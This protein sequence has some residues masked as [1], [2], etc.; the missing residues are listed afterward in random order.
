MVQRKAYIMGRSKKKP[1]EAWESIGK[2]NKFVRL[3]YEQLYSN[4]AKK[5]TPRQR[6]LYL[7]MK[8]QYSGKHT[9]KSPD[10]KSNHFCFSWRQAHEETALYGSKQTFY[11]DIK[12][13][14]VI[15]FIECVENNKNL[16]KK[17]IY[18]YSDKWK[19]IT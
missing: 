4:A 6:A 17:N 1:P 16:R 8:A 15:G 2:N 11:A 19:S 14:E 3:F 9:G 7:Y 5:L 10:G 18:A 13:L 12:A